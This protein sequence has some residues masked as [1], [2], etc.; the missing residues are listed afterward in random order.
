MSALATAP[1]VNQTSVE[2]DPV[3]AAAAILMGDASNKV[4]SQGDPASVPKTEPEKTAQPEPTAAQK[5]AELLSRKFASL[6][7]KE[8]EIQRLTSQFKRERED[9][10]KS[11]G[12]APKKY[13]S[14]LDMLE[15]NG[16][17]YDDVT[18]YALGNK[19]PE[20]K[21]TRDL[22]ARIAK[23]EDEKRAEQ[24]ARTK[25]KAEQ[26]EQKQISDFKASN[27]AKIQSDLNRFEL[28]NQEG[29]FDLYHDT[30]VAWY[31]AHPDNG[32]PDPLMIGDLVEKHLEAR[33][34]ARLDKLKS[35]KKLSSFFAPTGTTE[36]KKPE[37]T[38]GAESAL[39]IRTLTN[40]QSQT[41]TTE[42]DREL[43]E[44]E[45]LAKAAK[46]MSS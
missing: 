4:E 29:E 1:E 46:M 25:E 23:F 44:A 34:K 9:F 30:M 40:A 6:T 38:A 5:Q 35:Y 19:N 20:K 22:E 16:W 36:Q 21:A 3:Q 18:Q 45:L 13:D 32:A 37:T 15:A 42:S 27:K 12:T 11:K 43:T 31:N 26:E 33:E 28:L 41:A 2:A 8:R 7:T 10:E 24:E 17:T 39:G 14:P